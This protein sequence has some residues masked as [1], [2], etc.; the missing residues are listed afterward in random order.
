LVRKQRALEALSDCEADRHGRRCYDE[1]I[2]FSWTVDDEDPAV[3][4]QEHCG[5]SDDGEGDGHAENRRWVSMA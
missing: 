2:V 5:G 1:S 4:A 3:Q